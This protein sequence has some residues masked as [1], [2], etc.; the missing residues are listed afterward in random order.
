[1]MSGNTTSGTKATTASE[2]LEEEKDSRESSSSESSDSEGTERRRE[3]RRRPRPPE[4]WYLEYFKGKKVP[5]ETPRFSSL[6]CTG[7]ALSFDRGNQP[8]ALEKSVGDACPAEMEAASASGQAQASRLQGSHASR[9]LPSSHSIAQPVPA[10]MSQ[11]GPCLDTT[12]ETSAS[13][14]LSPA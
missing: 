14:A 3:P 1:M 2:P 7:S 5:E 12:E 8:E 6:A 4:G 13:T 11:L 9:Q 10:A